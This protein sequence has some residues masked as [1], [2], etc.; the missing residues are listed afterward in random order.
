MGF[1]SGFK[2]LKPARYIYHHAMKVYRGS[3]GEAPLFPIL[4]TRWWSFSF[5]SPPTWLPVP[6]DMEAEWAPRACPGVWLKTK[7]FSRV[8][9]TREYP[10]LSWSLYQLSYPGLMLSQW[11]LAYRS[12]WYTAS[13]RKLCSKGICPNFV[14]NFSL[15]KKLHGVVSQK[16]AWEI[17]KSLSDELCSFSHVR[18]ACE[19]IKSDR[20]IFSVFPCPFS[21]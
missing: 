13:P 6:I 18:S 10:A 2:G 19:I 8:A 14:R 9:S 16:R 20:W 5:T 15:F 12:S 1:N 7:I 3:G 21:L 17:I 4:G 11:D